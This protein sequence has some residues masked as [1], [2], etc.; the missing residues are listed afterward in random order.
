M[1][2]GTS[3]TPSWTGTNAAPM[4]L[5]DGQ[6][7][8]PQFLLECQYTSRYGPFWILLLPHSQLAAQNQPV[9]VIFLVKV[10]HILV[11]SWPYGQPF[12]GNRDGC[13]VEAG[14]LDAHT[15][16]PCSWWWCR[17]HEVSHYHGPRIGCQIVVVGFISFLTFI[18]RNLTHALG[19][20]N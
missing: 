12:T 8:L 3:C 9:T 1:L 5:C 6:S 20:Q 14:P 7:P 10:W 4:S 17:M 11:N 2:Q 13:R 15:V 16:L 18:H 19:P